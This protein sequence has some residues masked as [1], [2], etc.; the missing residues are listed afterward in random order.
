VGIDGGG[1]GVMMMM[2][3]H[4][5]YILT[6]RRPRDMVPTNLATRTRGMAMVAHRCCFARAF[7]MGGRGSEAFFG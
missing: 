6:V 1:G 3:L 7:V 2:A 4:C 5:G